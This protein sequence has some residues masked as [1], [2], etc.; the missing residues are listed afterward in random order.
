MVGVN[1]NYETQNTNC[2]PFPAMIQRAGREC[3][4]HRGGVSECLL[5]CGSGHLHLHEPFDLHGGRMVFE[6]G[7]STWATAHPGSIVDCQDNPSYWAFNNDSSLPLGSGETTVDGYAAT[8][9]QM[10]VLGDC[11]ELL[12]RG[13]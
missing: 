9:A 4:C 3:L 2:L 11:T 12:I 5:H 13:F 7:C 8:N 6:H 1:F 10:F